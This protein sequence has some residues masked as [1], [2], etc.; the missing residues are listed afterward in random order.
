MGGPDDWRVACVVEG[1]VEGFTRMVLGTWR[2][3]RAADVR[4][5]ND[6]RAVNEVFM[7]VCLV[8]AVDELEV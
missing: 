8:V 3:R 2:S 5:A 4:L 7:A 6:A 1:R